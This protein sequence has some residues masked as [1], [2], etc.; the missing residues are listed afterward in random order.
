ML[1]VRDIALGPGGCHEDMTQLV[2]NT[3][4]G[5]GSAKSDCAVQQLK[6]TC[7]NTYA[8]CATTKTL[9]G[10][11]GQTHLRSTHVTYLHR[12]VSDISVFQNHATS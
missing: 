4:A 12:C 11:T 7:E 1:I 9:R 6:H 5:F 3:L 8:T 10:I 2:Q